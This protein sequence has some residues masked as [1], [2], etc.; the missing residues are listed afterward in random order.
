MSYYTQMDDYLDKAIRV[1]G[2]VAALARSM[3]INSQAVS[4]WE[5]APIGRVLD[6]SAASGWKVTPH[7]LRP[8]IYP[9]PLDGLPGRIQ[10][11]TKQA[12]RG[13]CSA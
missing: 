11:K 3:K 2:G 1:S 13:K 5:K 12:T 4:Q 10:P 6:I 8:D 7:E 9:H